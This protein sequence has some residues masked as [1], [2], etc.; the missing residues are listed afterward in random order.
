M[1]EPITLGVI[2]TALVAGAR[3]L[4]GL[5]DGK[6]GPRCADGEHTPVVCERSARVGDFSTH[7]AVCKHRL[8]PEG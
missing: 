5:P 3:Y 6:L 8:D 2:V 1:S 7:C 4:A